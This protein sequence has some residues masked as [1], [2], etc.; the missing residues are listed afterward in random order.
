MA[1][2]AKSY[3]QTK[4]QQP[5][6][7]QTDA[8]PQG[9]GWAGD[10]Q[11][12]RKGA[13]AR[14]QQGRRGIEHGHERRGPATPTNTG[15]ATKAPAEG[16]SEKH[17]R[18][19]RGPHNKQASPRRPQKRKK[20]PEQGA[21]TTS[22]RRPHPRGQGRRHRR[23]RTPHG[24]R[25]RRETKQKKEDAETQE[26]P[27]DK[28]EQHPDRTAARG[29]TNDGRRAAATDGGRPKGDR[30]RS[31]DD[32]RHRTEKE[33]RPNEPRAAPLFQHNL[34]SDA[35]RR[36]KPDKIMLNREVR[37]E[38][39]GAGKRHKKE[40]GHRRKRPTK[41]RETAT[42]TP[43]GEGDSRDA[44][45]RSERSERSRRQQ[46]AQTYEAGGGD[47]RRT[48]EGRP[49]PQRR[50]PPRPLTGAGRRQKRR[51]KAKGRGEGGNG[52]QR[53]ETSYLENPHRKGTRGRRYPSQY[54][55]YYVGNRL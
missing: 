24:G 54:Q 52:P 22:G 21:Q 20:A 5:P 55:P 25:A 15:A 48:P 37:R 47:R 19:R 45:L 8:D 14:R 17:P 53:G 44:G 3:Q 43:R 28:P 9:R 13:G 49:P 10:G 29:G 2:N 40:R 6:Q 41:A 46:A 12:S 23:T 27:T 42:S 50:R 38:P 30:R 34:A 35:S 33:R 51:R 32:R 4:W 39:E 1:G 16:G 11:G 18:K 31:A 36:R 26:P 7:R